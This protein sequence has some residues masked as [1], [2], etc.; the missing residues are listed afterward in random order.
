MSL[1][2]ATAPA[3]A[4]DLQSLMGID[5]LSMAIDKI[6]S[7]VR[8]TIDKLANRFDQSVNNIRVQADAILASTRAELSTLLGQ[9]FNELDE[10]ER[11][12]VSSYLITLQQ[13]AQTA[14]EL[15]DRADESILD[16]AQIVAELSPIPSGLLILDITTQ[17]P[18]YAGY[19]G[20]AVIEIAG[21]NLD[22][23]TFSLSYA[24]KK[25]EPVNP[26]SN[27]IEF[28]LPLDLS[29][30]D[31]GADDNWLDLSLTISGG[32]LLGNKSRA[33]LV[34]LPIQPDFLGD[35]AMV[36]T[37]KTQPESARI[38][39]PPDQPRWQAKCSASLFDKCRTTIHKTVT[40]SRS[41]LEIVPG[42]ARIIGY[43]TTGHCSTKWGGR[44]AE[45]RDAT[46]NGFSAYMLERSQNSHSCTHWGRVEFK[47]RPRLPVPETHQTEPA[48][49]Y[50]GDGGVSFTIPTEATLTGYLIF[51]PGKGEPVAVTRHSLRFGLTTTWQAGDTAV[52]LVPR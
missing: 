28:H 14:E 5:P 9:T 22:E 3:N 33:M 23:R 49:F 20:R 48:P 35:I 27:V 10:Q 12:I 47:E 31:R 40:T 13:T 7:S 41:D 50:Y 37:I 38:V 32:G 21:M 36:Y 24:N 39:P 29:E 19:S 16:L 25:F 51:R 44:T 52:E 34:S 4:F 15:A 45:I 6:E 17:E 11:N 42:S 18:L 43:G 30:M 1:F 8:R 46:P 2:L 26:Q